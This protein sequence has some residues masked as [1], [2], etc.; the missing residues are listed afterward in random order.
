MFDPC[1][2]ILAEA[3]GAIFS[4]S[5]PTLIPQSSVSSK[6]LFQRRIYIENMVVMII[7][8]LRRS[9]FRQER[10]RT[11]FGQLSPESFS[12]S[13][14]AVPTG[15]EPR[16]RNG[17]QGAVSGKIWTKWPCAIVSLMVL[18]SSL[19]AQTPQ[20][21]ALAGD[22]IT[23]T[24]S[25]REVATAQPQFASAATLVRSELAPRKRRQG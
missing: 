16:H 15:C 23:F 6:K 8:I 10:A 19:H 25:V 4:I 20:P 2:A 5:G 9:D 3:P 1:A 14:V 12:I 17:F 7:V 18:C 22:R 11:L 21:A 13:R 24:G